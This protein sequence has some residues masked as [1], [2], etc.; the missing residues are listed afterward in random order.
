MVETKFGGDYV[1]FDSTKDGQ[2]AIILGEGEYGEIT[3]DGKTKEVLNI[4]VEING[5]KLTWTPGI[6]AGKSAQ[7]A[8]GT[9]SKNWV[10]KKFEIVHMENKMLIRPIVVEKV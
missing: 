7:K 6:R 3:Y 5:N 1:S 8:W 2:I 10:G 9:E 4:P